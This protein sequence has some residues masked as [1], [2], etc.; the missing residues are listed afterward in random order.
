MDVRIAFCP[1]TILVFSLSKFFPDTVNFDWHIYKLRQT[2]ISKEHLISPHTLR[3]DIRQ[4]TGNCIGTRTKKGSKMKQNFFPYHIIEPL[5]RSRKS[6]YNSIRNEYNK[7]L[8]NAFSFPFLLF[9]YHFF[10]SFLNKTVLVLLHLG[11]GECTFIHIR[12]TC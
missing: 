11:V 2:I 1:T 3:V 6:R 7:F 8:L 5:R 12:L 10:I 9:E 4:I